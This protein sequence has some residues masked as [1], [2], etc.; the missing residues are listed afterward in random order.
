MS[1][2]KDL[3]RFLRRRRK[4]HPPT[5]AEQTAFERRRWIQELQGLARTVETLL[6]DPIDAGCVRFARGPSL[7]VTDWDHSVIEDAPSWHIECIPAG[8]VSLVPPP[9]RLA[10]TIDNTALPMTAHLVFGQKLQELQRDAKTGRWR[11][12]SRAA[13]CPLTATALARALVDLL[14]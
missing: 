9:H 7:K 4:E 14:R 6:R 13:S 10:A 11:L 12:V 1:G 3:C 2:V 8:I 5:S